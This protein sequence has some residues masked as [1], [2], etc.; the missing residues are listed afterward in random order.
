MNSLVII[1]EPD[2]I[3]VAWHWLQILL[4]STLFL[5]ILLMDIML[6]LAIITFVYHLQN[7]NHN[8]LVCRNIAANLPFTIAFTINFGI[9]PL[10]FLQTLY[11]HFFYTSSLLM[12]SFWLSL[13]IILIAAYY[14]TYIY[15]YKF[16]TLN[17]G[18]LLVSGAV[19]L[20]LLWVA[21]IM[22]NN[23]T[24]M[25]M[26]ETWQRYFDDPSGLLLNLDDPTIIPRYL[27]FVFSALAMG[28]LGIALFFH[29]KKQ[30]ENPEREKWIEYGCKWFGYSTMA[31]FAIGFWFLGTI[32]AGAHNV[33]TPG[34]ALFS[35]LLLIGIAAGITAIING[36][37]GKVI[38]AATYILAAIL[39]MII[40]RELLR[41]AYLKQYFDPADLQVTS[42]YSPMILFFL[43][44]GGGIYLIIW[45]LKL[46]YKS[47]QEKEVQP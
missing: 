30:K 38:R 40:M 14:L 10:L 15:K 34:G 3:P 19:A 26:P 32:P 46:V 16:D 41:A 5:H 7:K 13:V 2:S 31:N 20:L 35:L 21:F 29:F 28:G 11:G 37:R 27:H 4:T 42:Q 23:F 25:Q 18:K 8:S 47:S 12:A 17:D 33:S 22:C 9:A 1:P 44:L 43:V 24:L 39:S 45:M 6:G 36:L